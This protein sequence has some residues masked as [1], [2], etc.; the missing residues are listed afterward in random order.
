VTDIVTIDGCRLEYRWLGAPAHEVPTI[1]FLHEGLG[2]ITQWRDFPS[3]LCTRTGFGGLVYNRQGYGGSDALTSLPATFMHR[4][5]LDVLPRVLDAFGITRP[6]FFGHSDGGSIA[7]IAALRDSYASTKLRERLARH[8]GENVDRLFTS[9]T[10][11]WLSGEFRGWN[12]EQYLPDI[13]FPTL[14]IQGRDDEY[15]TIKQVETIARSVKHGVET[16]MLD[17]CAHAPHIDCRDAVLEASVS[18]LQRMRPTP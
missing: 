8:H 2:S 7:S 16:L 14:V 13:L 11:T 18:F 17:N 6:I 10:D 9:W 12:I 15:G 5:A 1:V 3:E 4:E